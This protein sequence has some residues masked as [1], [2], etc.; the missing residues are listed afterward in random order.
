MWKTF[1]KAKFVCIKHEA[2]WQK[3]FVYFV[4]MLPEQFKIAKHRVYTHKR[5]ATSVFPQGF[6]C[7]H[8]VP[9]R[10]HVAK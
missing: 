8:S 6:S 1:L 7:T 3:N 2:L 5:H 9:L 4:V 10:F